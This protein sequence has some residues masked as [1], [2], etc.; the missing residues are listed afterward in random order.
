MRYDYTVILLGIIYIMK[1]VI[2]TGGKQY[3][4]EKGDKLNIEKIKGEAGDAV[5]FDNVLLL[6]EN[7]DVKIGT[8]IVPGASVSATIVEQHKEKKKVI[9]KFKRRKRYSVK[10][11]HRQPKTFIEIQNVALKSKK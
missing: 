5:N 3:L 8:P 9:Y 10:K 2:K 11:G 6:D 4:V 7:G 1:A